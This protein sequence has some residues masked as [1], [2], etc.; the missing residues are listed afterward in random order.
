[1]KKIVSIIALLAIIA[2]CLAIVFRNLGP[3]EDDGY[4]SSRERAFIKKFDKDGD[5]ELS[6]EERQAADKASEERK[7]QYI[8]KFD[9]DGDGELSKEERQAAGKASEKRKLEFKKKSD[10]DG[11]ERK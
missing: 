8:K 2:T 10:K 6:K 5:G 11:S 4:R 1:M 7:L 9:K 3:G